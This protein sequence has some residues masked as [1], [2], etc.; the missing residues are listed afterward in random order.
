MTSPLNV[1]RRNVTVNFKVVYSV[2]RHK[3]VRLSRTGKNIDCDMK[4]VVQMEV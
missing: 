2:G 4:K 3:C 1:N